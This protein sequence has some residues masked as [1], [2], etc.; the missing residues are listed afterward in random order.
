M[1]FRPQ[2]QAYHPI[3]ISTIY[4]NM[5]C[6]YLVSTQ[7]PS[8]LT[9][10]LFIMYISILLYN[11]L[12]RPQAY[13]PISINTNSIFLSTNGMYLS[14]IY[15]PI[16]VSFYLFRILYI[17]LNCIICYSDLQEYRPISISTIYLKMGCIYLVSTQLPS[18]LNS[19]TFRNVYIYL[20]V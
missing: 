2:E 9:S 20:I 16:N 1:L 3:S 8:N 6:I 17:Y 4:L 15:L 13:H 18:N 14:S 19:S 10:S 5:G 7:L 12:F 11:I